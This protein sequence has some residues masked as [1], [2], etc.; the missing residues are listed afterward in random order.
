MI[1]NFCFTIIKFSPIYLFI[2]FSATN[3]QLLLIQFILGKC[4]IQKLSLLINKTRYIYIFS[5]RC[6]IYVWTIDQELN[7]WKHFWLVQ[8]KSLFDKV[9]CSILIILKLQPV[10]LLRKWSDFFTFVNYH[11]IKKVTSDW[12]NSCVDTK[13]DYSSG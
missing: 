10:R 9:E 12:Y 6:I 13:W 3:S 8:V 5:N 7:V 2:I 1:I 11:R 4:A